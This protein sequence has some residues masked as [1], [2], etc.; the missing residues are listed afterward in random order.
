MIIAGTSIAPA[1]ITGVAEDCNGTYNTGLRGVTVTGTQS[2]DAVIDP[3]DG[4]SNRFSE[5]ERYPRP[6]ISTSSASFS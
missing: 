4:V 6:P 2:G 3:N 1:T 5:V